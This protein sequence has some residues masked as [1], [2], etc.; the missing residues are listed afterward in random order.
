M[1]DACA[2]WGH[3]EAD[4]AIC[5]NPRYKLGPPFIREYLK[6]VSISE[7]T[8]DFDNRNAVYAMK[9][10]ALLSI[11]YFKDGRFRQTLKDELKAV[12]AKVN[13]SSAEPPKQRDHVL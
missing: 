6:R 13:S 3:N 7:P 5:R 2:Y 4:L 10:H 8:A 11:L 1:F 9:F 12:M